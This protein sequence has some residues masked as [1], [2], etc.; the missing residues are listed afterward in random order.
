MALIKL[1]FELDDRIKNPKNLWDENVGRNM[2][3]SQC[4]LLAFDLEGA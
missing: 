2:F 3:A 4:P 1:R